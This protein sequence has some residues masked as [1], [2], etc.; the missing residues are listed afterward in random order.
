MQAV[1]SVETYASGIEKGRNGNVNNVKLDYVV[2]R[3]RSNVEIRSRKA[4]KVM[5]IHLANIKH[6][7]VS[8]FS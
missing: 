6:N 8:N 7:F 4:I 1:G 5:Y 3:I 2:C